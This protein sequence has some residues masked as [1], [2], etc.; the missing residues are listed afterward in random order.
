MAHRAFGTPRISE[1]RKL[2][3]ATEADAVPVT[4]H[5]YLTQ[6]NFVAYRTLVGKTLSVA[7]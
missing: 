1:F 5:L 2:L 4:A 6:R 7:R 3:E